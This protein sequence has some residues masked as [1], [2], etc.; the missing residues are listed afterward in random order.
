MGVLLQNIINRHLDRVAHEPNSKGQSRVRKHFPDV[1]IEKS[2]SGYRLVLP[3][4][5]ALKDKLNVKIEDDQLKIRGEYAP[6]TKEGYELV[7]ADS[8]SYDAF[9]RWLSI[10]ESKFDVERVSAELNNGLLAIELPLK[11]EVL[12]KEIEIQVK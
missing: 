10:D 2:G 4:P 7:H 3:L 12:P 9:E 8:F 1:Q 6:R 11:A 5:G